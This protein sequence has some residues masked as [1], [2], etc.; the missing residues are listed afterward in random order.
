MLHGTMLNN[1]KRGKKFGTVFVV[2]NAKNL[3][4][5]INAH[6]CTFLKEKHYIC[7]VIDN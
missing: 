5:L 6:T 4:T 2:Q 1:P 7:T 3:L